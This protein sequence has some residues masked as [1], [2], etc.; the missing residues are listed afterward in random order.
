MESDDERA[1]LIDALLDARGEGWA[2]NSRPSSL[3]EVLPDKTPQELEQLAR[4]VYSEAF[5]Y[6]DELA[7]KSTADL[8]ALYRP[9]QEANDQARAEQERVAKA[10]AQGE[11]FT[12]WARKTYWTKDEAVALV[13]GLD[14]EVANVRGQMPYGMD[15]RADDLADLIERAIL[16]RELTRNLR[17][18]KLLSWLARKMVEVPHGLADAVRSMNAPKPKTSVVPVGVPSI[19][20]PAATAQSLDFDDDPAGSTTPSAPADT[21]SLG[22]RAKQF[23]ALLTAAAALEYDPGA[24]PEGGKA[25]IREICLRRSDIFTDSGFDHAWKAASKARLV[26]IADKDKYVGN[27]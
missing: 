6:R 27:G 4:K 21:N 12:R 5:A 7:G 17:P 3:A 14:P 20:P 16:T 9:V 15:D 26:C 2:R 11:M 18:A 10:A 19:A 24:I 1:L 23:E 22:R 8:W 25:K 13:L